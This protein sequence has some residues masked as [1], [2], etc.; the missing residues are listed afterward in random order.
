MQ[1]RATARSKQ[2]GCAASTALGQAKALALVPKAR[3]PF[4]IFL[5]EHRSNDMKAVAAMWKELPV[6][7]KKG[8][9][10]QANLKSVL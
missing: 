10:V 7:K 5:A 6:E 8:Y 2:G 3:R 4:A 1:A 9:G